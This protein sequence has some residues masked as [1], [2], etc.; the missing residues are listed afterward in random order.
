MTDYWI[1]PKYSYDIQLC[2]IISAISINQKK[3]IIINK[4]VK[5]VMRKL[6]I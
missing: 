2:E 4:K 3:F 1:I 6:E 5:F